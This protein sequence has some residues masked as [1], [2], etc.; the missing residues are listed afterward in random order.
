MR[1]IVVA[2]VLPALG[3]QAGD[4]E[5]TFRDLEKKITAAK[6]VQVAYQ[7]T[8]YEGDKEEGQ[9]KGTFNLGEGGK[10]K[11]VARGRV[12]GMDISMDMVTDG[13]TMKVKVT[14]PGKE[15]EQPQPKRFDATVRG[16]LSR[17]GITAGL[18]LTAGAG[19]DKEEPDLDRLM[20][21]SDI[22]SGGDAKL[23]GRAA[24]VLQ[25][26]LTLG[27]QDFAGKVWLDATTGLPLKRE[28]SGK[29][30]DQVMRIVET[31]SEFKLGAAGAPGGTK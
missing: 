24:R 25:Y 7:S 14:P 6:T 16:G 28:L 27:T 23:D 29:M 2:L 13:K 11:V 1:Y 3:L 21:V 9:F 5:K 10:G 17:A 18:F 15:M 4:A 19:S 8:L 30:R 20:R 31:Y 12:K 26:K 22:K